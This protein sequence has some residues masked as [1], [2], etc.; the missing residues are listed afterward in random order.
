MAESLILTAH[1]SEAP[2]LDCVRMCAYVDTVY[3]Y[4]SVRAEKC[5]I[6]IGGVR[7]D[8]YS[9]GWGVKRVWKSAEKCEKVWYF[10]YASSTTVQPI[11]I[12]CDFHSRLTG[13][14]PFEPILPPFSTGWPPEH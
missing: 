13:F 12:Y 3:I 6:L 7:I 5:E 9:R 14:E 4:W 8:A 1:Y 2:L 11:L 10:N